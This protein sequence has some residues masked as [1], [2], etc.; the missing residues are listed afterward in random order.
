M[1]L[2]ER[3]TI[4][5]PHQLTVSLL[6]VI[7]V[8]ASS[9]PSNSLVVSGTGAFF[10]G[11]FTET[12]TQKGIYLGRPSGAGSNESG[13]AMFSNGYPLK[14]AQNWEIDNSGGTFRWFL[15][16]NLQMTLS[17][18]S[19]GLTLSNSTNGVLHA[20]GSLSSYFTGNL[21]VGTTTPAS[22]LV[23]QGCGWFIY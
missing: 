15:P 23:A 11:Q 21:G 12:A 18:D 10:N 9:S 17:N 5:L 4:R 14:S 19:N 22:R 1:G 2:L 13:R 8:L 16:S 6:R 7:L 3:H 20:K